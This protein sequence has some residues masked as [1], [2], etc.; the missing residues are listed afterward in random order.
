MPRRPPRTR[1]FAVSLLQGALLAFTLVLMPVCAPLCPPAAAAEEDAGHT[2][3]VF[4]PVIHNIPFE[5]AG[6]LEEV[7]V[8][9]GDRVTKGQ[10]L[11]RYRLKEETVLD[12]LSYLDLRRSIIGTKIELIRNDREIATVRE[13]Y[14]GVRRLSVAQMGSADRLNRLKNTLALLNRQGAL[15]QEREQ[16]EMRTLA[17][18][19]RVVERKLGKSVEDENVPEY[20]E[21]RSPLDGEVVLVHPSLRKGMILDPFSHAISVARTHPMEVRTRV[22]EADV[23]DLRIG[24][25]A[26]VRI[27]SLDDLACDGVITYIDRS[28][29]DMTVGRPSYYGVRVEIGN[30]DGRLR[31]GFKATVHFTP[32]AKN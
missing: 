11:A 31:A 30:E 24:G 32:E 28:P 23:P 26:V 27:P 20:G 13:E 21:L 9:P 1:L 18:R 3:K 17:A 14:E 4:C 16:M 5:Y 15:L 2:G 29:E 22:Y 25:K 19:R 8:S 6:M 7:L 10:V 12:I